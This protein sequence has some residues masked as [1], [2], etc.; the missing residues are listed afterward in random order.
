MQPTCRIQKRNS[1]EPKP[2]GS[3]FWLHHTEKNKTRT[4]SLSGGGRIARWRQC[5]CG[6][7]HIKKEEYNSHLASSLWSRILSQYISKVY[8]ELQKSVRCLK[9]D[10]DDVILAVTF[11]FFI[12]LT[13]IL[14][15]RTS[16]HTRPHQVPCLINI[17]KKSA[18]S[19]IIFIY[20][21]V[22]HP[23][24]EFTNPK[25]YHN[26]GP[27]TKQ[28]AHTNTGKILPIFVRLFRPLLAPFL[29]TYPLLSFKKIGRSPQP[30]YIPRF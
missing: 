10:S 25:E 5:K 13:R 16:K 18:I 24:L 20:S 4:N 14:R 9:T 30:S 27:K 17:R 15:S 8:L 3:A 21:S 1:T 6:L 2:P 22:F 23:L 7:S 11:S 19:N 12:F 28:T 29:T 26:K